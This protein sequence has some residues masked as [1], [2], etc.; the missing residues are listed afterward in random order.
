LLL[1]AAC[2]G[3]PPPRPAGSSADLGAWESEGAEAAPLRRSSR[4]S[5]APAAIG[6]VTL[7]SAPAEQA[8]RPRGR[9]RVDVNFNKAD[10]VTAFQFLADAG[11]FNLVVQ[12]GLSGQVS[13]TIHGVDPYDALVALADANGVGV[14]YDGQIAVLTKKK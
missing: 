6:A 14:R 10:M 3:S 8:P 4:L 2:A 7:K 1:L 11:H 13:A 5:V 12:D 9:Q